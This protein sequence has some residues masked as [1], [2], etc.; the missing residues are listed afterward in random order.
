MPVKAQFPIWNLS[1]SSLPSWLYGMHW[2]AP[3]PESK[4]EWSGQSTWSE[5]KQL[6]LPKQNGQ[7]GWNSNLIVRRGHQLHQDRRRGAG[8]EDLPALGSYGM[9]QLGQSTGFLQVALLT[10]SEARGVRMGK[11]VLLKA[12]CYCLVLEFFI[13]GTGCHD[14]RNSENKVNLANFPDLLWYCLTWVWWNPVG[15]E[16]TDSYRSAAWM[17]MLPSGGYWKLRLQ[18]LRL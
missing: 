4:Q 9:E 7:N 11:E 3:H 8:A 5:A 15:I 10:W 17:C 6:K 16:G 18:I 14:V 2:D 1:T 12:N 13:S